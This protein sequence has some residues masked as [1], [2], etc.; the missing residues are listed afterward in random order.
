[1]AKKTGYDRHLEWMYRESGGFFE[2][3]FEAI[4]RADTS[5]LEKLQLGF[6][7]EVDAVKTWKLEGQTAFLAKVSPDHPILKEIAEGKKGL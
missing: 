6:P 1:M 7:E 4:Y 5:H 3:L 2:Y